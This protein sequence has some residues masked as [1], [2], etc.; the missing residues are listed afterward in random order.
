MGGTGCAGGIVGA[1]KARASSCSTSWWSSGLLVGVQLARVGGVGAWP[2]AAAG[3]PGG[4][5]A[6]KGAGAAWRSGGRRCQKREG[7]SQS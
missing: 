5:A 6:A 7:K 4:E 3:G 1:D 2:G